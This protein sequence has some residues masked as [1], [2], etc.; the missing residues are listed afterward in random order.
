LLSLALR[1][2]PLWDDFRLWG[3][4]QHAVFV[5]FHIEQEKL[6]LAQQLQQITFLSLF[7]WSQRAIF[8]IKYI[9]FNGRADLFQNF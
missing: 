3:C 1:I 8:L 9:Y 6:H 7:H 5:V 4:W 2:D